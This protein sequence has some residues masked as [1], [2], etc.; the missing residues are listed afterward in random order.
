MRYPATEKLE[1]SRLV[2]GSHLPVMRT[3]AMIGVSRPTVYRWCVRYQ[4]FG[5]SGLEDRRSGP[6]RLWNRIPG[7]V[8][9]Q[10]VGLTLVTRRARGRCR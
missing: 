6:G 1:V 2:A 9:E 7:K 3:L 5:L 10:V 8:R 4:R